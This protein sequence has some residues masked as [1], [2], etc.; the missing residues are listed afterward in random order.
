MRQSRWS[1]GGAG[2]RPTRR[3]G[4][5]AMTESKLGFAEHFADLPDPRIDRTKKHLLIDV[6]AVTLC[7]TIAG[8]ASFE[9]VERFG[10]SKEA[11]LRG[12]LALPNGIPSHDTFNR[13]FAALNPRKFAE[14]VTRWLAA[15]CQAAGLKHVAIDGKSA[16][17]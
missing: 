12:F 2:R 8:A 14:A 7:A 13:V 4:G 16:C 1:A 9:E 10:R 15:V 3:P 6:L 17:S 11:W 5:T